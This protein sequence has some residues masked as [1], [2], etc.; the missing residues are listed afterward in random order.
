MFSQVFDIIFIFLSLVLAGVF[1][2]IEIAVVAA[3]HYKLLDLKNTHLWAS[4]AF[5]LKS[6]MSK[7]IIF[8]LFASSVANVVFTTLSTFVLLKYFSVYNQEV[9]LPVTTVFISLF[10]IL[11]SEA[12]PKLLASRMPIV[13][14]RTFSIPV[15]YLF[16]LFTPIVLFIN[17]FNAY[18]NSYGQ[19]ERCR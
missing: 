6:N 19:S 14:L 13:I 11:F 9:V 3:S 10:I 12:F 16:L 8:S 18:I 7:L 1:S 17:F 5:K 2:S 15:Y 4:Y